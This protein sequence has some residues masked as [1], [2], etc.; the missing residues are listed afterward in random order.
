M[1]ECRERR[2]RVDPDLRLTHLTVQL[3]RAGDRQ[4][5][6]EELLR[7]QQDPNSPN[8]HRWLTPDEV[9]EQFG[10][11]QAN[12]EAVESWLRSQNLQVDGTSNSRVWIKFSGRAADVGAAFASSMRNYLVRG[13]SV[14]RSP[15]RRA[16]PRR[17]RRWCIRCKGSRVFARN[18][19]SIPARS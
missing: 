3:K 11:P 5:A 15:R 17:S 13:E 18:R 16:C 2:R 6:F 19:K 1:G 14:S 9:G 4:Q 8:F 7:Q 12:I 10:A